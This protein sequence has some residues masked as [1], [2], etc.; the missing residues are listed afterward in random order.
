MQVSAWSDKE[1]ENTQMR[2]RDMKDRDVM[3]VESW[4]KEE[5]GVR[6]NK[7]KPIAENSTETLE[8]TNL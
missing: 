7:W 2:S 8:K 5:R 1:I 6:G 4:V 3:S